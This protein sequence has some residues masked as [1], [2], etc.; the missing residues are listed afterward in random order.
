M[1]LLATP[2]A[3][4]L[5]VPAQ[6]GYVDLDRSECSKLKAPLEHRSWWHLSRS[7]SRPT[8]MRSCESE[9]QRLRRLHSLVTEKGRRRNAYAVTSSRKCVPPPVADSASAAR[10]HAFPNKLH[11]SPRPARCP[12]P[13]PLRTPHAADGSCD[14]K[15][16][17]PSVRCR[18]FVENATLPA[19]PQRLRSRRFDRRRPRRCRSACRHQSA[20]SVAAPTPSTSPPESRRDVRF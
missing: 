15:E 4:P 16:S 9:L 1:A 6:T 5:R 12:Q 2:G 18:G 20:P 10:I 8:G 3:G 19:Q 14:S 11:R 13:T 17:R 7:R